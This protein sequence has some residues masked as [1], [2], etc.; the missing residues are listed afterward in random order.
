MSAV[1]ASYTDC[2]QVEYC[3]LHG[4]ASIFLALWIT[5]NPQGQTMEASNSFKFL[6][7]YFCHTLSF[8]IHN[9]SSHFAHKTS[10][11]LYLSVHGS[12]GQ[13]GRMAVYSQQPTMCLAPGHHGV[14]PQWWRPIQTAGKLS[15]APCTALLP[16]S[17]PCG[18]LIIHKGKPWRHQ[19]HSNSSI[20]TFIILCP[21]WFWMWVRTLL[22]RLHK[23]EE[24]P[25]LWPIFVLDSFGVC[26]SLWNIPSWML[27]V[28]LGMHGSLSRR[29]RMAVYSQQPTMCWAPGHHGVCLQ[30]WRPIQTAGKLSTAPCTALL[31]YSWPC[32]LLIIHKGKPWRH[33]I[34]SNSSITTFIILCPSW[35]LM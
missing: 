1:V 34:H 32:G 35:F 26:Q 13:R 9:V 19:I 24:N 30:W 17:W 4:T 18:L 2:W 14:C 21:S 31:P 15:T 8:L 7:N 5:D 33:Q 16:Y 6:D 10:Y 27:L 3:S 25:A 12:R 28:Y 29:G 11:C 23:A 20:T 22:L